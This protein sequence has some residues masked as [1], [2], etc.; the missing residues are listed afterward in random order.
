MLG[1]TDPPLHW[2]HKGKCCV[3]RRHIDALGFTHVG[4]LNPVE[5][6]PVRRLL[7]VQ[8]GEQFSGKIRHVPLKVNEGHGRVWREEGDILTGE[9]PSLS[10]AS[11]PLS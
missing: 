7:I 2:C 1:G 3:R 5:R 9:V 10:L 4:K 8:T 11:L 6:I